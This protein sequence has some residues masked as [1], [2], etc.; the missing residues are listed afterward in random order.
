MMGSVWSAFTDFAFA[1]LP[2]L[3]VRELN[4]PRKEKIVLGVAMSVGIL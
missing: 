3:M 4:R 1:G 2:W